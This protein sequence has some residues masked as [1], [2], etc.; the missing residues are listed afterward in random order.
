MLDGY[1]VV[2]CGLWVAGPAIGGL[3]ADWGAEVIKVEPPVGDPMRSMYRAVGVQQ[4]RVPPYELD[5]RGKRCMVLDLNTEIDR[6]HMNA[7]L[8]T[9]DVFVTNLRLPALEKLGLDHATVM[10]AFPKLIYAAVTGYGLHGP[11]RDRPGYDA[12]AFWARSSLGHNHA[13]PGELPPVLRSGVGDHVT[14]ITGAAGVLAALLNREKTGVGRVVDISL[15]RTGIYVN[16]WDI[17]TRQYFGRAQRNK[18]RSENQAPLIGCYPTG[19]GNGGDGRGVW[20]LGLEQDRHWPVLKRALNNPTE[21]E[22]SRFENA[23]SR[24]KNARDLVAILDRLFRMH[25]YDDLTAAFD[26]EGMWWAPINSI[27]DVLNDPQ[28]IAAGAFVDMPTKDG[29]PPYQLVN[30]PVSFSD[31]TK[32]PGEVRSL[33]VDTEAILKELNR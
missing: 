16:G 25:T 29:E 22:D 1:R 13:I 19:D 18:P 9:A 24:G 21:L 12:G 15:L 26:R 32:A 8:A 23:V 33:G 5:N 11:D 20:L 3:F 2:E 17:A 31:W 14:G 10:A 7:L 4:D 27:V 30:S 28:A 6:A